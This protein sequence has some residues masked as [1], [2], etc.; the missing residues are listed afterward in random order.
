MELALTLLDYNVIL[1]GD[2]NSYL[3]AMKEENL[4]I[5]PVEEEQ[6]TTIKKRTYTQGQ[7]HKADKIVK[8]SKDKIITNLQIRKGQVTYMDGTEPNE[9][10]LVPTNQHPFDHFVVVAQ[11]V[12]KR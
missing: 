4:N 5:F 11:L 1:G 7:F 6:I 9:H 3:G 12:K 10:T 2:L 8:E